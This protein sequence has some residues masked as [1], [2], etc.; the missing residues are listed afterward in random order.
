LEDVASAMK[1]QV[2]QTTNLSIISLFKK[3][4]LQ[5]SSRSSIFEHRFLLIKFDI[6]TEFSRRKSISYAHAPGTGFAFYF[7][8]YFECSSGFSFRFDRSISICDE[9]MNA[10][11]VL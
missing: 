2:V 4:I 10:T 8:Q 3:R 5:N 6:E 1:V 9:F 11:F 7:R